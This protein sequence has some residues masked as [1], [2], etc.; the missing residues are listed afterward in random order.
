MGT[1]TLGTT[2]LR[3]THGRSNNPDGLAGEAIPLLAR[4]VCV[5]DAYDAMTH[6][7]AYRRALSPA[8]ARVPLAGAAG[9][10]FDPTGA[11]TL[12]HELHQPAPR[13]RPPPPPQPPRPGGLPA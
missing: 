3:W 7:R 8:E 11:A 9:R 1:L 12:P 5:V 2:P 4:I 13:L 10:P 6:D